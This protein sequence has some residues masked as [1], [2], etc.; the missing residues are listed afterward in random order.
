[1]VKYIVGDV[2]GCLE[3]LS[4]LIEKINPSKTDEVVFVGDLVDKGPDSAG[5]VKKVRGLK[6]YC[7]VV[8]VKGNHEEKHQR[9]YRH[10]VK[11]TGLHNRIKNWQKIDEIIKQLNAD[12]MEFI[13]SAPIFYKIEE[14]NLLVVH[15]GITPKMHTLP[16]N[17][18]YIA[19][20][21]MLNDM[22]RTRYVDDNGNMV[23]LNNVNDTHKF[24]AE[25]YDGRFGTV[26][27]GHEP[28]MIAYPKVYSH[29]L[30]ID[31]GC[32]YG[33][34]LCALK[35]N[36]DEVECL[37]VSAKQTYQAYGEGL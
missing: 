24:W 27:Y 7:Q 8:L 23:P 9:Y 29:A 10:L 35:I 13:N 25:K 22:L 4:E 5:V 20:K 3:E 33:N 19:K 14:Y 1:M 31:L 37:F 36:G 6:R 21:S 32:V 12:D 16:M 26:V 18:S 34:M 17:N 2:H 30:G 15:G 11:N 28:Y